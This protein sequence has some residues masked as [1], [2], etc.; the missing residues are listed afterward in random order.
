MK[1]RI[2]KLLR[3]NPGGMSHG[4][5][6]AAL[7]EPQEQV[8]MCLNLMHGDYHV[9]RTSMDRWH[10]IPLSDPPPVVQPASYA[11]YADGDA[12]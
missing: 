6:A 2:Q 11:D 7:G 5:I 10:M 12:P 1:T 8:L 4:D 3:D 9:I